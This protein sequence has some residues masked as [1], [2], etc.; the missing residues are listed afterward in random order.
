MKRAGK[1]FSCPWLFTHLLLNKRTVPFGENSSKRIYFIDG[2]HSMDN[3][4]T[5]ELHIS[6]FKQVRITND[7]SHETYKSIESKGI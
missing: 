6:H 4:D 3:S 7:I 1:A 2:K 5:T